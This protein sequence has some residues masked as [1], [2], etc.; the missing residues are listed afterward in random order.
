MVVKE[1]GERYRREIEGLRREVMGEV[2]SRVGDRILAEAEADPDF[3]GYTE[4]E[5]EIEGK[6]IFK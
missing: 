2:G 6:D 3:K 1:A 5:M 4:N